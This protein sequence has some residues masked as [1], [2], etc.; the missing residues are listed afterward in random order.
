[1]GNSIMIFTSKGVFCCDMDA[2]NKAGD[3]I[4]NEEDASIYIDKLLNELMGE[5][6][7][8]GIPKTIAR[9]LEIFRGINY[10]SPGVAGE[11]KRLFI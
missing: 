4:Y 8:S 11:V 10:Y 5:R 1:M 6:N 2:Y 7:N 9:E 3:L